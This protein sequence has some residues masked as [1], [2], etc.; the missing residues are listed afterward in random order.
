LLT[1]TGTAQV[2][3]TVTAPARHACAHSSHRR[4]AN[5]EKLTVA[6]RDPDPRVISGNPDVEIAA[7]GAEGRQARL[8][9]PTLYGCAPMPVGTGTPPVG[10]SRL[11]ETF[12]D[13]AGTPSLF[14]TAAGAAPE[15][16]L[17]RL[18]QDALESS[19]PAAAF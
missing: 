18:R 4:K 8:G 10:N 13:H 11:V 5:A 16:E 9:V 14:F 1:V 7:V 17:R 15:A 2:Q 6:N 3:L 12:V 19:L